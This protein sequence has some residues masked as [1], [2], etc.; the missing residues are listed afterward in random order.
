V[1]GTQRVL[2]PDELDDLRLGPVPV[3][4][5]RAR[6]DESAVASVTAQV[7][8]DRRVARDRRVAERR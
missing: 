2:V 6:A 7:K 8:S 5:V 3:V 4:G 1:N